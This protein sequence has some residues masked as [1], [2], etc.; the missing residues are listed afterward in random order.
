MMMRGVEKQ[1]SSATSSAMHGIFRE[2]TRT[3]SEFLN[4]IRTKNL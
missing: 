4:L 2:D 1:N 3:R